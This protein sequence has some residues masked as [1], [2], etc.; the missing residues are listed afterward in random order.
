MSKTFIL[1]LKN[2]NK[3]N[4]KI[5]FNKNILFLIKKKKV[6]NLFKKIKTHKKRIK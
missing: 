6:F 5:Y 1:D 4:Y 3:T 2:L